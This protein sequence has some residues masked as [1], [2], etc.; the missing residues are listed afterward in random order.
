MAKQPKPTQVKFQY[1][2]TENP[3][4]K[5]LF[6]SEEI[7][8]ERVSIQQNTE[9]EKPFAHVILKVPVEFLD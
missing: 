1:K 5:L 7:P 3:D 2:G 9:D 6:G 8:F 4:L